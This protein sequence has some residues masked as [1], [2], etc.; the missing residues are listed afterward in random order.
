[1]KI[2]VKSFSL[3]ASLILGFGIFLM[4]WWIILI[5]GASGEKTVLGVV[6][7]GYN[8]SALGSIIGLAWGLIDGLVGGAVFAWLYN[9]L[10][11]D[12]TEKE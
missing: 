1:M 12:K 8:I 10:L 9:R 11:P 2:N 7:L 3:A 5:N 6:Y 4:T